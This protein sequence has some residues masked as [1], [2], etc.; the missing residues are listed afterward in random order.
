[1]VTQVRDKERVDI[2]PKVYQF[3]KLNP[4][5]AVT[6]EDIARGKR[7]SIEECPLGFAAKRVFAPLKPLVVRVYQDYLEVVFPRGSWLYRMPQSAQQFIY[8][9]DHGFM[10]LVREFDCTL[11]YI[12]VNQRPK[13]V[14]KVAVNPGGGNEE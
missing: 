1:M 4:M 14:L 9:F 7:N 12:P 8:Q 2:P 3:D 6:R 11:E 10:G 13:R 5:I